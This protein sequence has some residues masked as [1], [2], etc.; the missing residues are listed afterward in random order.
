MTFDGRGGS[1][2]ALAGK[3]AITGHTFGV[4]SQ[5]LADRDPLGQRRTFVG[6]HAQTYCRQCRD[7]LLGAQIREAADTVPSAFAEQVPRATGTVLRKAKV[8]RRVTGITQ[9]TDMQLLGVAFDLSIRQ[10]DRQGFDQGR[11][12]RAPVGFSRSTTWNVVGHIQA[13]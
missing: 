8:Q 9:I 2:L 4:P 12:A 3:A 11:H 7:H 10:F 5:Q 1:A 6:S 13:P